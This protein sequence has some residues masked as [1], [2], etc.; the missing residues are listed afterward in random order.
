M[1]SNNRI[2]YAIQQI[3]IRPHKQAAYKYVHGLQS[4]G[5][6][7]NFNLTQVYEIGQLSIYENIEEIPDVQI[8]LNKVLDGYPPIFCLATADAIYPTLV[9]RANQQCNV[10]LTTYSESNNSATG[11][12]VGQMEASG[13]YV[14]SVKYTFP[15]D[16]N[17]TEEIT[18]VGNSKVWKNDSRIANAGATAWANS[19]NVSG[20][21]GGNDTPLGQGGVNRRQD[22]LFGGISNDVTVLPVDVAGINADGT[23]NIDSETR[24]HLNSISVSVNLNRENLNELGRRSPYFRVPTFPVEV[25]TEIEISATSGDFV[26]ATE[27]GILSGATATLESGNLKERL[28]RIAVQEG[29]RIYAGNKNKLASVNYGGGDAGG[30]VVN[31]SYTYHTFND[32][33][34]MHSGDPNTNSACLWANR[35]ASLS[36]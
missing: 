36:G 12:A 23:Q 34:V 17:F 3:A 24:A 14:N 19:L 9:E 6:T 16:G 25:S 33:T 20:M 31:V 13:L 28:I 7:T 32:L 30:G 27:S 5:I 2:Y 10:N 4:V 8:T 11:I 18:L 22:M 29:L 1:A 35:N 15:K 21:F 26:S